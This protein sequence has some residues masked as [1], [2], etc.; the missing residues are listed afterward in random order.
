MHG[1]KGGGVVHPEVTLVPQKM[2]NKTSNLK[3]VVKLPAEGATKILE[4]HLWI[5]SFL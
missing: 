2:P 3:M 5:T 4:E 1:G